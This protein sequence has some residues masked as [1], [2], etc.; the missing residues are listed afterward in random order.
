MNMEYINVSTQNIL[1]LFI[2]LLKFY[3]PANVW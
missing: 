2:P 3:K 1:F